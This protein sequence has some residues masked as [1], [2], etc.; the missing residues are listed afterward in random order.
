MNF[1][2]RKVLPEGSMI[3]VGYG[4]AWGDWEKRVMIGGPIEVVFY[5]VPFNYLFAWIRLVYRFF[6]FGSRTTRYWHHWIY[7]RKINMEVVYKRGLEEGDVQ[8]FYRGWHEAEKHYGVGTYAQSSRD[9]L[10]PMRPK[11]KS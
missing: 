4:V 1:I 11:S 8:G 10:L 3:P 7:Q 5:P 9:Y 6:K 2:F